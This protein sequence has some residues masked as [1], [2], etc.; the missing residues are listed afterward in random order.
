MWQL[1][2]E[3]SVLTPWSVTGILVYGHWLTSSR[4]WSVYWLYLS[5]R[6]LWTRKQE[7]SLW[8]TI[9]TS[10]TTQKSIPKCTHDLP[11]DSRSLLSSTSRSMHLSMRRRRV[12]R[13]GTCT[14]SGK[15]PQ[16]SSTNLQTR[17]YL[18]LPLKGKERTSQMMALLTLK[19]W[20]AVL[21][22]PL[23]KWL[24]QLQ[25]RKISGWDASD[26][27]YQ[28]HPLV[29]KIVQ[30]LESAKVRLIALLEIQR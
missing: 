2:P 22:L 17:S 16:V 10:S 4:S 24:G 8:R 5:Q 13:M 19:V 3:R 11:W 20:V 28:L 29:T 15:K 27:P 18:Q 21:L 14:C 23:R 26:T 25:S 9:K 30:K 6:A 1:A 12:R 7:E